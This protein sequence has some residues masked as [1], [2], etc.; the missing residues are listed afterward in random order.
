MRFVGR[1]DHRGR[2]KAESD[3]K[4]VPGGLGDCRMI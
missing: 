4:I 3:R 1:G 2:A